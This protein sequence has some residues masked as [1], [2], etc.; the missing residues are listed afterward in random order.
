MEHLK[1]FWTMYLIGSLVLAFVITLFVSR[2]KNKEQERNSYTKKQNGLFS[3]FEDERDRER[4]T[5][6]D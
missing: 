6:Y 4:T 3:I 1:E 2:K 5:Y